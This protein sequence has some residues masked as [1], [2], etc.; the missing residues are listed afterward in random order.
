MGNTLKVGGSLL[1]VLVWAAWSY[2]NYKRLSLF[3]VTPD[4]AKLFFEGLTAL[5]AVASVSATLYVAIIVNA[6]TEAAKVRLQEQALKEEALE[7]AQAEKEK[8]DDI[9][10]KDRARVR[11]EAFSKILEQFKSNLEESLQK[12]HAEVSL[13]AAAIANLFACRDSLRL[14]LFATMAANKR[15]FEG[16]SLPGDSA[17]VKLLADASVPLRRR[18]GAEVETQVQKFYVL[19]EVFSNP[20]L[21]ATRDATQIAK[22]W[23]DLVQAFEACEKLLDDYTPQIQKIEI[24]YKP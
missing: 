12:T 8:T 6:Q 7:K 10:R 2:L 3:S 13:E 5:A 15:S 9:A 11:E 23:D 24:K 21:G 20:S 22:I 16:H 17:N 19:S 14:N 4:N 18:I 1:V